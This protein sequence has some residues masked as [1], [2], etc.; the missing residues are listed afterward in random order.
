MAVKQ[1]PRSNSVVECVSWAEPRQHVV[2]IKKTSQMRTIYTVMKKYVFLF[3]PLHQLLSWPCYSLVGKFF[4]Y[5]FN[6][7]CTV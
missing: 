2:L 4:L 6:H 1:N 5:L 3:I 7:S